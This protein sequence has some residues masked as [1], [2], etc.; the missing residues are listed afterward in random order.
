MKRL[1]KFS[2]A[3]LL[4]GTLSLS[5]IAGQIEIGYQPPPEP[6]TAQTQGVISTPVN[7]EM[8]TGVAGDIHTTEETA[9]GMLA[10]AVV[11]LV[12]G[13]LSLL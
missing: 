12:Q 8:T 3:L 6:N 5:T 10:G 2:A 1:Q 4:T 7:G 13:V 9:E 11:G